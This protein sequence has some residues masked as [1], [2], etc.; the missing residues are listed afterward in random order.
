MACNY[1]IFSILMSDSS[2]I[3]GYVIFF[4]CFLPRSVMITLQ[5]GKAYFPRWCF[6]DELVCTVMAWISYLLIH[7]LWEKKHFLLL[8]TTCLD[9]SILLEWQLKLFKVQDTG[10]GSICPWT[11]WLFIVELVC[12]LMI[13]RL[14][15]LMYDTATNLLKGNLFDMKLICTI[16]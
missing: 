13:Y 9:V 8:D 7:N 5:P 14:R 2:W 16:W 6:S 15:S 11:L 3:V 4:C 1:G 10:S 12:L